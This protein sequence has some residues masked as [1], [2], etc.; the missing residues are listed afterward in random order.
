M[1]ERGINSFENEVDEYCKIWLWPLMLS[2]KNE[3]VSVL[4]LIARCPYPYP[5]FERTL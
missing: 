2:V 4:C 3:T 1:K 5:H